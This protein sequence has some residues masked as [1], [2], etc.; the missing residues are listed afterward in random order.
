M[1][2]LVSRGACF[3]VVL[4]LIACGGGESQNAA[5]SRDAASAGSSRPS[6]NG[7]CGLLMQSE[8][9]ELFGTGVG[10]GVDETLDGNVEICSWPSG[11]EPSLL[12]QVSPGS[13][14]IRAA[15]DLGDGYRVVDIAEMSGPA[16]AA[17]E[18]AD[19]P[20]TVVVFAITAGDKTVTISPFGLRIA[21][22]SPQFE[23]LKA[24]LNRIAA[25]I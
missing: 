8:V 6:G 1:V 7:A 13:S 24:L 18:E 11:D 19:G 10:A 22:A 5:P 25:R 17:I 2:R 3:A 4:T 14:E 20:E 21:P 12:L 15:V 23:A 16:A 9:D